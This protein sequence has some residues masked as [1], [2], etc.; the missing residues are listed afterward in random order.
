[1]RATS[2][3]LADLGPTVAGMSDRRI[4]P[5]A[6]RRTVARM[7]EPMSR[8]STRVRAGGRLDEVR[9]AAEQSK[10]ARNGQ[11]KGWNERVLPLQLHTMSIGMRTILL[12]PLLSAAV[13]VVG[14]RTDVEMGAFGSV[15]VIAAVCAGLATLLPY[16][17]LFRTR[18]GMPVVFAWSVVNLALIAIGVWATGGSG[19]PLVFLYA[20]TTLFFAVAFTPRMQVVFFV[21]SVASY[22]AAL[23]ASRW[24][25]VNLAVLGVLA[26][27]ANLLVGQLKSQTVAHREARL[28][29][30]RRWALLA[31]VSAAARDM[32]AVE[33]L[34]VLRAVVD[35]VVALG[36]PTTRIYV[37]EDGYDRAILPSGVPEDPPQ[38]IDSLRFEAVERV[39]SGAQPVVEGIVG[40]A[41][42][43]PLQKLGLSSLVVIPI[44]VD[45]RVEAILVVGI[46]EPPG[47]SPQDVEVFQ[48]LTTQAAVALEN[49]RR[50]EHQ[51]RSM[52][53]VAELDRMK[54]DFLSNISHELRTPLTVIAGVGRTLELSSNVLSED[55]RRDLLARSNANAATLDSM[56]TGLLDFGRLEAGQLDVEPADV[57]IQELFDGVTDRLA[58]LFSDHIVHLDIEEGLTANADPLLIERVVENLLTNAAKYA[59]PGSR[60]QISAI[61]DGREAFVAVEDDGPGIPPD[62]LSHIGERFFR[63]GHSNTR[64]TRGTGL[65]LALVSEILDLHGTYL[66]VESKLGVGSRFSFRLPRGCGAAVEPIRDETVISASAMRESA[67]PLVVSDIGLPDRF[68]TVL[69]AAQM[70]LEWPV[71]A[72][73][74]EFHPKVLRY[75]RAHQPD[76]AEELASETWSDIASALPTFEGNETS[77]RRW[78]FAAARR[79]LVEARE[80]SGSAR[81]TPKSEHDDD[82]SA[83]RRAVDAAIARISRLAPQQADA[84]LLRALGDLDVAEVAEIRGD[85]LDL[86]HVTEV[87]GLRRLRDHADPDDVFALDRA[88]RGMER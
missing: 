72:L 71:A 74:R 19:S 2:D 83:E 17:R 58:S 68:E 21:L 10:G 20:L 81:S 55:E 12:V 33:P 48:M 16:E 60:V 8:F 57:A 25:P 85:P 46:E 36:F 65:G 75:L 79:R 22:W 78:V 52:E 56:L 29:S 23:G 49:A 50:F 37:Q 15:F 18:W 59:P 28:E 27:L 7:D 40:D 1:L 47:P 32:S 44:P 70:G 13:V 51:R 82:V 87:E 4:H 69:A 77:F 66:E 14:R 53:R 41:L 86:A 31:V 6:A 26:F 30:E 54:S 84:L 61:S 80:K 64:S 9:A 39:L 88:G 24:N 73:C 35:S 45:A 62:E 63:G 76:R 5:P 34:V 38:G 67:Q 43:E 3:G 42:R 11:A